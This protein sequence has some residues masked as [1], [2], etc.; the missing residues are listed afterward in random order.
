MSPVSPSAEAAETELAAV[1]APE[2]A[3]PASD[4]AELSTPEPGTPEPGGLLRELE[5]RQDDVL[6]QIDDLDA[7]V[8]ALLS[9]LGVTPSADAADRVARPLADDA[10]TS[11]E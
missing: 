10:A 11:E 6:A 8:T 7:K 3:T 5:R 1:D 4:A 2:S 9:E